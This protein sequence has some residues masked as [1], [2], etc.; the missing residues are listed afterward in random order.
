MP[1]IA[2]LIPLIALS[3]SEQ[4]FTPIDGADGVRGP[5]IQVDP[6]FLGF[7]LLSADEE[8]VKTFTISSVGEEALEIES[9]RIESEAPSFTVLTDV[10]GLL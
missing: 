5:A 3:C 6:A 9:I 1:R 7:G 10:D 8:S 2:F 4:K